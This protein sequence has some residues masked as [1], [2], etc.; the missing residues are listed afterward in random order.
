M[1]NIKRK[2]GFTLIELLVVIAIIGLLSG[3]VLTFINSARLSAKDA[4]IKTN[5]KNIKTQLEIGFNGSHYM[6][7]RATTAT[8]PGYN[9]PAHL[10][11]DDFGCIGKFGSSFEV[12]KAILTL[13]VDSS[14]Q[15]GKIFYYINSS[16]GSAVR[17]HSF[18]IYGKL[19]SDSGYYF[20]ADSAG[21]VLQRVPA[22]KAVYAY[23]R[24]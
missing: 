17:A 16:L 7:L 15:G 2:R 23:C 8:S 21:K 22:A 12:C 20:C 4:R 6:D 3:I 11:G 24:D 13:E 18:A 9:Q 1:D 19:L 5:V 10:F 14:N